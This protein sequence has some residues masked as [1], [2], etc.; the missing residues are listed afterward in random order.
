MHTKECS[1][2]FTLTSENYND[3]CNLNFNPTHS[4]EQLKTN[5]LSK[6]MVD[7]KVAKMYT[8]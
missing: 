7:R 4:L 5:N 2:L 1:I 3:F 6:N 8:I